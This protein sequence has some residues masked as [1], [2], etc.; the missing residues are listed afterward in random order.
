MGWLPK[1]TKAPVCDPAFHY[2]MPNA[3]QA[4][5][6]THQGYAAGYITA[7]SLLRN[8]ILQNLS[9]IRRSYWHWD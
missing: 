7:L 6:M 9:R 5:R 2:T 8:A 4:A 1:P 3:G